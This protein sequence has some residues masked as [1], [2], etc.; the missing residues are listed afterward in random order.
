[1]VREKVDP[2]LIFT[3]YGYELDDFLMVGKYTPR[4]FYIIKVYRL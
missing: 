3:K 1:M 4:G 2:L